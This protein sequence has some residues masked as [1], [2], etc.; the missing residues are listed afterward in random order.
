MVGSSQLGQG[1]GDPAIVLNEPVVEVTETQEGLYTFNGLW[2]LPVSDDLDLL[3]VHLNAVCAN[4]K[5][6]VFG[7]LDS[8]LTLFDICLKAGILESL[9]HLLDMGFVF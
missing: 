8:K 5:A 9:N 6:K 7:P 2:V 1:S 3:G 4:D